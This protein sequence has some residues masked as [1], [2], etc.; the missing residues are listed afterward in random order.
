R[1]FDALARTITLDDVLEAFAIRGPG[2]GHDLAGFGIYDISDAV[3]SHDCA[4]NQTVWEL[5]ASGPYTALHRFSAPALS[6]RRSR[7]RA[8]TAFLNRAGLRILASLVARCRI[9][10]DFGIP[11]VEIEQDRSRH[12]GNDALSDPETRIVLFE[13]S[14]HARRGIQAVRASAGEQNRLRLPDHIDRIQQIGFA[15]A[16][17][18]TANVNACHG[19][20]LVKDYRTSGRPP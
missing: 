7:A 12:N 4:H 10:P 19:A 1:L 15:C 8:G 20:L 13:P 5:D 6:D 18:G 14:D 2:T 16:G 3:D 11:D 9:G 17:R